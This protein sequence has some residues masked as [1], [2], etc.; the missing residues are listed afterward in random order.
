MRVVTA[1]LLIVS[2]GASQSGV[3]AQEPTSEGR[4]DLATLTRAALSHYPGL[5]AGEQA[6]RAAEAQLDEA[7]WSPFFRFEVEGGV[8]LAPQVQGS[9]IYSRDDQFPVDGGWQPVYRIGLSGAVPLWTFGKLS[10]LRDAARAGVQ[11]AE[12]ERSVSANRIRRDVRFAYYGL[13]AAL[14]TLYLLEEGRKKLA[15][16]ESKVDEALADQEDAEVDAD[17]D[18]AEP[19]S[20]A[21]IKP[22]DRYRLTLA[23][24]ELDTAQA[25]A[26]RAEQSARRALELLTGLKQVRISD[27]PLQAIKM[28]KLT[29]QGAEAQAIEARP[30]L[31]QLEAAQKARTAQNDAA[32]A[33]FFPDLAVALWTDYSYGPGITDQANPFIRDPANYFSIGAAVV[34]RWS[35]DLAGHISRL[36]RAKAQHAQTESQ[37]EEAELAIRLA[38]TDAV[39]SLQESEKRVK[40]WSHASKEARKWFLETAQSYDLGTAKAKDLLDAAKGYFNARGAHILAIKDFN[41]RVA[42]LA[43]ET[44]Q[45]SLIQNWEV[46]CD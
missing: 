24:A 46:H 13:A 28:P 7:T 2:L 5:R 6:V 16:A 11:A 8:G 17:I 45:D 34:A 20:D 1:S 36:E 10:A 25:Q 18:T 4:H 29:T 41:S 31:R 9:P 3:Q 14:D 22:S 19:A 39:A 38:A 32:V 27:C 43:Y 15:E 42:A 21:S 26:K 30:E 40:T 33:S 37:R 35:L 23:L 12:A 44:A